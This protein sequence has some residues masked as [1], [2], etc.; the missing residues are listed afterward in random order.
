MA[1]GRAASMAMML[2]MAQMSVSLCSGSGARLLSD[3]C[4]AS[5]RGALLK[6][7][8]KVRQQSVLQSQYALWTC[9]KVLSSSGARVVRCTA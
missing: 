1:A 5:H 8:L 9:S 4:Q 3:L 6:I 7:A 2:W